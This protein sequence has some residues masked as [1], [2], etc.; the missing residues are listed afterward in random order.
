[1]IIITKPQT[2]VSILYFYL[3]L[4]N[5]SQTVLHLHGFNHTD[6]LTL[7]N[8]QTHQQWNKSYKIVLRVIESIL[9][10]HIVLDRK[11]IFIVRKDFY[12]LLSH[13]SINSHNTDGGQ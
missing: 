2:T 7:C 1:M 4:L 13:R 5:G 12:N 9:R 10:L 6:L 8:L 3:G 11:K